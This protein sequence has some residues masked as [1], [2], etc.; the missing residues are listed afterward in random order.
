MSEI[1]EYDYDVEVMKSRQ[2]FVS[3]CLSRL[4]VMVSSLVGKTINIKDMQIKDSVLGKIRNYVATNRW[5]ASV[6]TKTQYYKARR[7]NLVFGPEGQ[8]CL[9]K[10][11]FKILV[12]DEMIEATLESYHDKIG[13]PGE[14]NTADDIRQTYFWHGMDEDIRKFVKTCHNCQITKPNLKPRKP[15]QGLSDTPNQPF[16]KISFDL[17][18]PMQETERGNRYILVSTDLFSKKVAA[19]PITSK[20]AWEVLA[21]CKTMIFQNPRLPCAILTDNGTEFQGDFGNYFEVLKIRH[22]RSAP[23]NSQANGQ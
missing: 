1:S 5:P 2:M 18:G 20:N 17:I 16:Q 8:L 7:E 14:K 10:N 23:Y 9:D 19:E 3:D 12:P 4:P 22:D 21:A 13:H 15:N 6:D 11:A